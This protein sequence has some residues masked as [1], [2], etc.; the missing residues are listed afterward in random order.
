MDEEEVNAVADIMMSVVLANIHANGGQ[1]LNS[2]L[3]GYLC[4]VLYNNSSSQ[5]KNMTKPGG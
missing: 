5:R 1:I 3:E 2:L 4:T